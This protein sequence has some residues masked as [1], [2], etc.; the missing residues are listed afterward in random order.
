MIIGV[1]IA[2]ASTPICTYYHTVPRSEGL[3]VIQDQMIAGIIM[4][5][6]GSEMFSWAR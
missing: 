4:W 6:P 3:S 5:I 2:F 1:V